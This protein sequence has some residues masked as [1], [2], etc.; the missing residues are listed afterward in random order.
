MAPRTA[1]RAILVVREAKGMQ[2]GE[3]YGWAQM[4]PVAM[5]RVEES[6]CQWTWVFE[7][8]KGK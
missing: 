6:S 2:V 7:D 3:I 4:K 1:M 8:E 5:L